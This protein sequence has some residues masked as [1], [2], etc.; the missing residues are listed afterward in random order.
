MRNNGAGV[1]RDSGEEKI[2]RSV[3]RGVCQG[4]VTID[5]INRIKQIVSKSA[6]VRKPKSGVERVRARR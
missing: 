5:L 6:H 4:N 3:I 1:L 2:W